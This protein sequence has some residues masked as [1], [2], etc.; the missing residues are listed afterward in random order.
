MSGSDTTGCVKK[1]IDLTM[2]GYASSFDVQDFVTGRRLSRGFYIITFMN[3][4]DIQ[5]F[6]KPVQPLLF[7]IIDSH[8]SMKVDASGKMLFLVTDN[9]TGKPLENQEVTLRRNITRMYS[10]IWNS[11]T[12]QTDRTYVSS[13]APAFS[14]GILLGK[15]NVD[16]FLEG[17]LDAL[18][19][20]TYS[21]TPYSLSFEGR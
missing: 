20:T 2:T 4:D 11:K 3:T 15:T 17:T 21:D 12:N 7:S 16:G 19:G 1:D 18:K 6:Q 8:I 9:S 10:E 13:I 5:G 14:T